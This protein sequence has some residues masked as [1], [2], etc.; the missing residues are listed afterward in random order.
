[1]KINPN[2][3]AL[4]PLVDANHAAAQRQRYEQAQQAN[5]AK[6][7]AERTVQGELVARTSA[8]R[9]NG[10]DY[11]DLLRQARQQWVNPAQQRDIPPNNSATQRGITAYQEQSR[12]QIPETLAR[13]D[14]YA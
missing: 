6:T 12:P 2:A 7:P 11:A 1:M 13:V 3:S 9:G 8:P 10:L 4:Y 14:D 5:T